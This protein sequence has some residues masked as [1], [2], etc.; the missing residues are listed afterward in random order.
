MRQIILD[1]ETTGLSPKAGHRIIE[2]GCVEL[3]NRRLTGNHFHYYLNPD[4]EIDPGAQAVHGITSQ[5][6]ADKPRFKEIIDSLIEYIKDAQIIIHNADF[7]LGFLDSEFERCGKKKYRPFEEYISSV[8][9]TLKMARNKHPGQKN[10][11]DVLCKRY[12]VDNSKRDLHGALL[13]SEILAEVY[14]A[15]TGGQ[16]ALGLSDHSS[17]NLQTQVRTCEEEISTG[18]I[19]DLVVLRATE[20]E[21]NSHE[22]FKKIF[23]N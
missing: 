8:I 21:L 13:D 22:E 19:I 18:E 6:L 14:L 2:I 16:E 4:R 23:K 17:S 9:C 20:E 5:F 1:T 15:M 12:G 7:D 11:L 10:N 3:V